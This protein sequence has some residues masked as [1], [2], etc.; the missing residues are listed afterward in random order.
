[1]RK[2]DT[3]N[4]LIKFSLGHQINRFIAEIDF[5]KKLLDSY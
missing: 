5:F 4:V 2:G 3:C 1:M